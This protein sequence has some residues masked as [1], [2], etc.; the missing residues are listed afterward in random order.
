MQGPTSISFKDIVKTPEIEDL[1]QKKMA[2][3]ERFCNYLISC[4]VM[5]EQPQRH[6]EVGNPYRVRIDMKVPPSHELIVN[7]PSS[8]GDMHDPLHVVITKAFHKAERQLKG[9]VEKQRG[10]IK[11]HPQQQVMGIV[12]TLFPEE[13][14]GFIKTVDTQQD[15]YFHKNSVLHGQFGDLQLGTGVRFIAEDGKK[16]LQASTVEI[17]YKP[18]I[19]NAAPKSGQIGRIA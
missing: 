19:P 18:G 15:I 10:D 12:H 17:I 14:Y 5:I 6:Q 2:K 9:L 4:R 3:L 11:F 7:E 13:G 1:I 8:Q 16:G